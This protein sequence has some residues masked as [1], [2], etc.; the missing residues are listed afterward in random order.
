MFRT[1]QTLSPEAKGQ[2]ERMAEIWREHLGEAL[3]GV[4]LH[5]SLAQECFVEGTSDVDVL[6]VTDRRIPREERLSI[7]QSVIAIDKKPSPLEMSAIYANDLKPWVYPPPC[8]F[9]YSD[10]WTERYQQMICGEMKEN[11]L[12][13]TDFEDP[14]V[15]SYIHLIN[16]CGICIDGKP[17]EDVFPTVPET[18]FWCGISNDIDDYD[19]NASHPR[20][21]ASNILILAR[22]LS[23]KIEKRILSKHESALWAK[24]YLPERFKV[25]IESAVRTWYYREPF[26]EIPTEDLN[27]FRQVLIHE[28]K[29]EG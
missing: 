18:D 8:Q 12:I 5:G 13:D 9:H 19:F 21:F 1:Y 11:F 3:T 4:Y 20:Y 2:I 6:I 24:G 26:A 10:F 28:I 27:D 7:A 17:I 23:Y 25:I 16:Q 14:D 15:A 29:R 22:I